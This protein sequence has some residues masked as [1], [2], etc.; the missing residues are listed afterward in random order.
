MESSSE[1]ILICELLLKVDRKN[2]NNRPS[3]E[4]GIFIEMDNECKISKVI[5]MR[6]KNNAQNISLICS[7]AGEIMR[8]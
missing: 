7:I 8:Q 6:P 4:K 1:M 2:H 3:P 5:A